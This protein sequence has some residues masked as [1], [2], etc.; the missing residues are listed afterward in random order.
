MFGTSFQQ[1]VLQ[2]LDE[3]TP[4]HI[5]GGAVRDDF[6]GH[7]SKDLDAVIALPVEA[8]EE[9]LREWGYFPHRLGQRKP[10][11][12]LFDGQ[13]RLDIGEAAG[14]L[15][16]DALQRDFTLNALYVRVG[17]GKL[18][19]PLQGLSDLRSGLLRACG[20][21]E[22]R[23]REDPIRVLRL[24]RMAVQYGF[25]V[26]S[27]TWSAAAE[28]LPQLGETAPERVTGELA[29]ILVL[30]KVTEGLE[31]LADLG[32]WQA[33]LPELARLKGLVQ[34]RYHTKDAWEHTLEVVKNTPPRLLLRLAALWH[35]LGKWDTAS[36]ECRV[37]G[38]VE[39]VDGEW[40][41]E[42]FKLLGS[43]LERWQ[44]KTA[45]VRGARL[46]HHPECIQVKRMEPQ[47]GFSGFAWVPDGKRHF[48]GHE[49]E[50]AKIAKTLL[51]RYVWSMFLNEPR[52]G[53]ERELLFLVENH[54][55][56]TL[57]FMAELRGEKSSGSV[58]DKAKRFAWR[59]GWNGRRFDAERLGN[60]LALWRADFFGGKARVPEDSVRFERVCQEIRRASENVSDRLAQL[61]WEPF[62]AFAHHHGLAPEEIGRFQEFIR[63]E[64]VLAEGFPLEDE[65]WLVKEWR[66]F[67]GRHK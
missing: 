42:G 4:V 16:E 32:Y 2:R 31:M 37:G 38:K 25:R 6:L 10:T 50:S 18:I 52:R 8:V 60:L 61:D 54:M 55:A 63:P 39:R 45:E 48:L 64:V 40:R 58:K 5:V 51:P 26:E 15:E 14:D 22:D 28:A 59:Y 20:R 12:T 1:T 17:T 62:L 34:N 46:D 53:G 41:I 66:K 35:D 43:G 30:D 3:L 19:D 67:R 23:F 36:R 29:R 65:A 56:G 7:P 33:Y 9:R 24:V 49:R 47:K 11:V 44:G 57:A 21:A 27:K 13:E